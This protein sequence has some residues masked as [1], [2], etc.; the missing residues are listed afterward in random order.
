MTLVQSILSVILGGIFLA[1]IFLV[2]FGQITVRKLRKN[3]EIKG[4]LGVNFVSGS[5]IFSVAQALWLPQ[6]MIRKI[7]KSRLSF[8]YA[9]SELLYKHTT[10]FDRI[11][12]RIF[13]TTFVISGVS[14]II[15]VILDALGIFE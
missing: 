4:I 8:L 7:Q 10:V 14:M 5:D 12:A 11:L 1:M 6:S 2:L 13:Y 9:D 15:L 3:P